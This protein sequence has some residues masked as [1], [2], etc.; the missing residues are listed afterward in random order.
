MFSAVCRSELSIY[1][2]KGCLGT[3]VQSVG[4][5]GL[6]L[7]ACISETACICLGTL[8]D[9]A[10][11]SILFQKIRKSLIFVCLTHKKNIYLHHG[12]TLFGAHTCGKP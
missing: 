8:W 9:S 10:K 4:K 7:L 3:M 12:N 2:I 6:E 11:V 1:I 5:A